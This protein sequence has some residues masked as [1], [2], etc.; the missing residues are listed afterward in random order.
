MQFYALLTDT[1]MFLND[2]AKLQIQRVGLKLCCGYA[3]LAASAVA[4]RR[5]FWK[6]TP[7]LHLFLHLCE[8]DVQMGN[9]R[10]FW[11]F[12]DED[13]VGQMISAGESCHPRT[14]AVT[15]MFKWLTV[16]CAE[17]E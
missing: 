11:C 4:D 13:L 15:S 3:K 10:K 6:A 7:K 5:K 9:P 14:L 12:A 2:N 8:W 16:V 1:G 17:N